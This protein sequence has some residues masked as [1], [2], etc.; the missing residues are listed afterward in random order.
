MIP[1]KF[2]EKFNIAFEI[3]YH[4]KPAR[5]L[6][7]MVQQQSESRPENRYMD[8]CV[9]TCS[10]PRKCVLQIYLSSQKSI[11]ESLRYIMEIRESL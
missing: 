10:T 6:A 9:R 5:K 4:K 8:L 2:I 11:R 3:Q 1:Y 7:I